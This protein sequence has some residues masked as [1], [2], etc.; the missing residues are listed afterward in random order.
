MPQTSTPQP[1]TDAA[2]ARFAF[3]AEARE[4]AA[5][6]GYWHLLRDIRDY[7]SE[8]TTHPKPEETK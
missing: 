5:W 8:T 6:A 7:T 2:R 3:E 4:R 1:S